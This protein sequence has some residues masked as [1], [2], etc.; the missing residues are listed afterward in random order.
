MGRVRKDRVDALIADYVG[1]LVSAEHHWFFYQKT[2]VSS[3]RAVPP[4]RSRDDPVNGIGGRLLRPYTVSPYFV[5]LDEWGHYH[6][7]RCS[8]PESSCPSG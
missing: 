8:S 1:L 2:P 7:G 5:D 6:P 3:R 4:E